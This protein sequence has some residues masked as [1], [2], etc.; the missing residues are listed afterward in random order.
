M[1]IILPCFFA[2]LAL[3]FLALAKKLICQFLKTSMLNNTPNANMADLS[4]GPGRVA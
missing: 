4:G 1:E 3:L 2:L